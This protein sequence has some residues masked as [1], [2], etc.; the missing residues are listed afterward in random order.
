MDSIPFIHE[1]RLFQLFFEDDLEFRAAREILD[2]LIK[3]DAFNS[4]AQDLNESY[5][6]RSQGV[7]FEVWVSEM[8]VIIRKER[9]SI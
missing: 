5:Q 3:L 9:S 4:H 7:S 1:N 2:E 6:M 8:N